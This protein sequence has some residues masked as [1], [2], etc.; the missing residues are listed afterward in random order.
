MR[1]LYFKCVFLLLGVAWGTC[2][3]GQPLITRIYF[4]PGGAAATALDPWILGQQDALFVV[5]N[6]DPDT[7]YADVEFEISHNRR[8]AIR[9]RRLDPL[10][11]LP[12]TLQIGRNTDF[13]NPAFDVF[14]GQP[15]G[16]YDYELGLS[17]E[18]LAQIV[19]TRALLAGEWRFCITFFEPGTD[20]EIHSGDCKTLIM[21]DYQ[22]PLPIYPVEDIRL[23]PFLPVGFQW[24]A[25]SPVLGFRQH[26]LLQIYEIREGQDM[27]DAIRANMP[28]VEEEVMDISRW[29]WSPAAIFL[30]P[31]DSMQHAWVVTPLA[32]EAILTQENGGASPPATF[33][34]KD[35]RPRIIPYVPPCDSINIGPDIIRDGPDAPAV[36]IG[37]DPKPGCTYEWGSDRGNYRAF[38]SRVNVSPEVDTRYFLFQTDASGTCVVYDELWVLIRQDFKVNLVVDPCGNISPEIVTTSGGANHTGGTA[39]IGSNG[40]TRRDTAVIL[41]GIP[42]DAN[43]QIIGNAQPPTNTCAVQVPSPISPAPTLPYTYLWSNGATT[44]SIHPTTA[45]VYSC[46]VSESSLSA[47]GSIDY[48]PSSRFR[49]DFTH[50]VYSEHMRLN[51]PQR[52]FVIKQNG[53]EDGLL[54]VYNA[55]SYY[56]EINGPN[57]FH[58]VL[59]GQTPDGFQ[60]SAIRWYGDPDPKGI[61]ALPGKYTCRVSFTNCDHPTHTETRNYKLSYVKDATVP[62]SQAR[63]EQRLNTF[64]IKVKKAKKQPQ[65]NN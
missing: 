35:P 58:L 31:G 62:L 45:G 48:T 14:D 37:C 63:R 33:W 7:V 4:I 54:P 23:S 44:S 3:N 53:N 49:G 18:E 6:T 11:I 2:L 46:T 51:D 16:N 20:K 47:V 32:P 52:P 30:N 25:V 50:F 27:V 42:Y 15:L 55:L 34:L 40:T 43:G 13:S 10:P 60:N 17:N 56:V 65:P 9:I 29:F 26:V 57:D 36:R 22:G 41:N 28:V 12:G 21:T 64:E 8:S 5:T 59:E 61:P 24:S 39:K 1:L 38:Q 19:A